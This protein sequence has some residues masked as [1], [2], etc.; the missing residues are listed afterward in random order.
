M[1][2]GVG[3]VRGE[4]SRVRLGG[5]G[6]ASRVV[7]DVGEVVVPFEEIRREIRRLLV[8][9]QRLGQPPIGVVQVAEIDECRDQARIG[10]ERLTV[11]VGSTRA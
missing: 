10:D 5:L 9:R 8:E 1:R 4:R 11:E 6:E 3:L 7:Q 2:V